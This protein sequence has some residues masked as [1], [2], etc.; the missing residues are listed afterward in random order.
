MKINES[1]K[2]SAWP[3]HH[4]EINNDL[5]PNKKISMQYEKCSFTAAIQRKRKGRERWNIRECRK[6]WRDFSKTRLNEER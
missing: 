4:L 6:K 1:S 3:I 2:H 5:S